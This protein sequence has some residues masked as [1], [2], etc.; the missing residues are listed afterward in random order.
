MKARL[1]VAAFAGAALFAGVAAAQQ[2]SPPAAPPPY[3]PPITLAQAKKVMAAAEAE[4]K[5]SP[6]PVAIYIVEPSGEMVMMERM[7]NTQY[8]S[9]T[10]AQK[11]AEAS[12]MFKRPSQALEDRVQAKVYLLTLGAPTVVGGGLPIE[13]GGK[14]IGAIGVSG[15]PGSAQ[16]EAVAKAGVEALGKK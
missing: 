15:S 8:G 1:L 14:I 2:A 11:K 13:V 16:D 6:S 3:G 4:A 7:D 12:A 9:V 10:L 5:K